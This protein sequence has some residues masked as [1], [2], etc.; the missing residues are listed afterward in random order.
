MFFPISPN[1]PKGIICR[2]RP[3]EVVI[4]FFLL[5]NEP[6]FTI[7]FKNDNKFVLCSYSVHGTNRASYPSTPAPS[8]TR[9]EGKKRH[10][11]VPRPLWRLNHCAPDFCGGTKSRLYPRANPL[12]AVRSTR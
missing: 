11:E 12:R 2:V 5:N 4:Q 7:S 3:N 8:P 10:F 9:G 6:I 1:P